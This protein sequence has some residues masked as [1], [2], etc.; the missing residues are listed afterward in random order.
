[1]KKIFIVLLSLSFAFT[2]FLMTGCNEDEK[3]WENVYNQ[4]TSFNNNTEYTFVTEIDNVITY[5]NTALNSQVGTSGN[6]YYTL[7]NDYERLLDCLLFMFNHYCESLQVTPPL[8]DEVKSKY[9]DFSAKLSD[10]ENAIKTFKQKKTSFENSISG[11]LNSVLNLQKLR[12]FKIDFA[13]I[14]HE[15]TR[16]NSSFEQLYTTAYH[17]IPSSIGED[18]LIG[19]EALAN[20]IILNNTTKAFVNYAFSSVEKDVINLAHID[21]TPYAKLNQLK[22][23]HTKV[24]LVN[25]TEALQNWLSAYNAFNNELNNFSIALNN[26]N[27]KEYYIDY[28]ANKSNY[29]SAKPQNEDYLNTI[30]DFNTITVGIMTTITNNLFQD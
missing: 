18:E 2:T 7:K 20:S 10:F 17:N 19:L 28:S 6:E 15:A 27:L 26:V 8:N 3:Y 23:N 9:Y 4:I 1:M 5:N 24:T 21:R 16:F 12:V 30:I 13:N 29:V 22:A 14:I 11:D 25:R